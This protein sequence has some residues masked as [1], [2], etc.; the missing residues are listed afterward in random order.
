[1]VGYGDPQAVQGE[2]LVAT[3]VAERHELDPG[4]VGGVSDLLDEVASLYEGKCR[5]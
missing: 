1:M 2:H 4:R 5:Y 3:A